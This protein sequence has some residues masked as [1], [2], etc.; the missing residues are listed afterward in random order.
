MLHRKRQHCFKLNRTKN[1]KKINV[2]I[3]HFNEL[4]DWLVGYLVT[5]MRRKRGIIFKYSEIFVTYPD[6]DY[7]IKIE[8]FIYKEV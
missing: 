5:Q 8:M 4:V 2:S 6:L 1:Y 3:Y 7:T